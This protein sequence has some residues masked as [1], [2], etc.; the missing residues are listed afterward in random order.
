[1]SVL[2]RVV[3]EKRRVT[4]PL[5]AHFKAGSKVT[6]VS[7]SEAVFITV[8]QSLVEQFREVIRRRELKR[9]FS[10]LDE[11]ENLLTDT[12]LLGLSSREIEA[13]VGEA[14]RRPRKIRA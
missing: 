14:I 10:A 6:M 11:W 7:S 4:L 12:G 1:M 3:D 9:R 2:E 5:D 13:R 8:D